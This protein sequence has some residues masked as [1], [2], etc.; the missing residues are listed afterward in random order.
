MSA[1]TELDKWLNR[2]SPIYSMSTECLAHKQAYE[3]EKYFDTEQE[4]V[5]KDIMNRYLNK[6]S[7]SKTGIIHHE[8]LTIRVNK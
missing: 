7:L 1:T 3:Y 2:D 8:R 6:R 5:M 4:S